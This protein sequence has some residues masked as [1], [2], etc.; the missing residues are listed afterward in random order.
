MRV[1]RA[2]LLQ[3]VLPLLVLQLSACYR[4]QVVVGP[5]PPAVLA[6][7]PAVAWP[8]VQGLRLH[9]FNTGTNRVSSL[10]VGS[11]APWRPV[12]A[13]VIEHPGKGLVVFD[14]GLGPEIARE[15]GAAL[16]PVTRL[17]FE[18]DSPPGSDLP[19]QMRESSMLPADVSTV[20]LSHLHF[21]HVGGA[22]A[23]RRA[24]FVV[25][26]GEREAGTS[27]MNGFEPRHT[28]WIDDG[29]WRDI[30]FSR[31][32]PYATFDHGVDLFGDGSITLIAGGGHT[33]GGL[34][35]LVNLPGGPVLLAG[36]LVVHFD[37]LESNDVQRI[38]G[39]PERAADV[40]NRVR[41]LAAL[42]PTLVIIPG[43]DLAGLPSGRGDLVV[44]RSALEAG[45]PAAN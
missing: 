29:A 3:F 34:A 18:T 20:I 23:F 1:H 44:H 15:G 32:A 7:A 30:D 38:V 26:L 36:D 37:W 24:T 4:P 39:S 42:A 28:S 25:G 17:L 5:D 31:A 13:F 21:D 27:R 16:H 40:R 22:D 2:T 14:C 45:R 9:V 33:Q 6:G 10:L 11:P 19:S 43:H 12:P 35:A 41:R 8:A